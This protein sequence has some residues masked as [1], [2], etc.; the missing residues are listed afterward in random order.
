MKNSPDLQLAFDVGH[1]S[2][3]W[4]VLQ[5]PPNGSPALLGCGT[6]IFPADDCLASQRR[7]FRRQRRH[8]RAT[9]LRIAR[10]KKLLAHLEVLT[11]EHLD[12][13]SSSSPWLL[14]AR[15]LR[16]G[17]KLTWSELW[18]V[19][20]WYAHN[21]GYDGNKGWSRQDATANAEDTEK[22]QK[23]HELLEAFRAKHGRDGTMAEVFCDRLELDPL[24][25]KKA[26]TMRCAILARPFRAKVWRRKSSASCARRAWRRM[27]SSR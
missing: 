11:A 16:G 19:L 12:A 7:G 1:S 21:R 2:I 4:A 14:A 8:I 6:V 25:E 20:R 13:V 18:D 15:V 23:A 3:G 17:K 27:S 24:A 10:L 22:E 26:S 5:S 9:R